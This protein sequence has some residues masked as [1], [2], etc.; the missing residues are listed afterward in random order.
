MR[1]GDFKLLADGEGGFEEREAREDVL[2]AGAAKLVLKLG[3]RIGGVGGAVDAPQFVDSP[4]EEQ[5]VD[6]GCD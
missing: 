1:A 4:G 5:G 6:L 2:R 3:R